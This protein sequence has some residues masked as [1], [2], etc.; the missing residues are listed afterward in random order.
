M[1]N[2][3]ARLVVSALGGAATVLTLAAVVGAGTKWQY[4]L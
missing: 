1:K 2:V 4:G 3:K